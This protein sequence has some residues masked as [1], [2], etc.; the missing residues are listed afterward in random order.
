M[1]IV[2]VKNLNFAY[3]EADTPVLRDVSLSVNEGD[4]TVLCGYSGCGKSTLLRQL[5]PQLTPHGDRTGSILFHGTPLECL[6]ERETAADIGF[7]AQSPENQIVT[8]KVWHE[9]AF[10]AESLGLDSSTIRRRVAETASFFGIGNWFY[11]STAHLSGGQKQLLC[12]ASAMVLRPKILILDEPTAQLDP[13]AAANFLQTL[14]K[15]NQELGTT[16]LLADHRLED[17][18]PMASRAAVMEDGRLLFTGTPREAGEFLKCSDSGMF[19]AMPTAMRI[20]GALQTDAPC[21]VSPTEGRT[22]LATYK[23]THPPKPL[24]RPGSSVRTGKACV[25]AREVWFRYE[26]DAPD[27]L[28]NFSLTATHGE[29]ICVLGGNGAGKTTALRVLSGS[30]KPYRGEVTVIGRVARLPQNPQTLFVKKTVREDLLDILRSR[31]FPKE[32]AEKRIGEVLSLCRLQNLT[33]RHPYDLS[34][35]EQ[36]RA[37]LAKVL[38]TDPEILLLDEPTK[39]MDARF[40]GEFAAILKSLQNAGVCIVMVSHD[41]EFCARYADRCLLFFDGNVVCDEPPHAFFAGNRFY[42]TAA[43]HIADG[44]MPGAVTAEDI[45]EAFGGDMSRIE[46]SVPRYAPSINSGETKSA[47]KNP[48]RLSA[49]RKVGACLSAAAALCTMLYAA[50]KENLSEMIGSDGVTSLGM[51]QLAVY[52]VFLLCLILT[53]CFLGKKAAPKAER[54]VP[55]EKR[56]LPRRTVASVFLILLAVPLTLIVGVEYF[57]QQHYYLTAL[58]VLL[59]CSLPFFLVFE[60]KRPKARELVVVSVLCSLSVAGRAAFFMLPQFK[61]VLA[62]TILSG[63]AFGGETGFLVGAVSMLVSNMLFSQGPWT[64]WQMFAMGII[65][66][67]AGILYRKGRLSRGRISLSL[68]G[69]VCAVLLYGGIMNFSSA[70]IW[71]SESLNRNI[72]LSYYITGFPMD[73][74]HAAATAIFLWFLSDPMLEKLDRIKVKYGLIE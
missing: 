22:F 4:F 61:P 11:Q 60:G 47:D 28:K 67:L 2:T 20:W 27:I 56:R 31:N 71:A 41:V 6:S 39:G 65:G 44:I 43:A 58:T 70:L 66:F 5:K 17:V 15:I 37:A 13:I 50:K 19:S 3:P 26:K 49:R 10:G 18:L 72:L 33:E 24:A 12:L 54:I 57:G 29:L 21:P 35:G 62:M 73:C 42:T 45:A 69:A 23:E 59:E 36:Q 52:W 53:A 34:G 48:P 30:L 40:K 55:K 1:E 74:V 68:F 63:V 7:V 38:L 8:D 9:L 25:T 32:Q 46:F 51:Q 16:V 14:N 64:P